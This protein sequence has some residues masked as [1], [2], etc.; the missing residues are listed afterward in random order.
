MKDNKSEKLFNSKVAMFE[1][2]SKSLGFHNIPFFANSPLEAVNVIRS[3]VVGGRDGYLR[4]DLDDLSLICVGFYD[5]AN[6]MI[7][8]TKCPFV[9]AE[10]SD[11]P[12]IKTTAKEGDKA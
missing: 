8:T 4:D 11:I 6:G 12:N 5:T 7:D 2:S 1:I 3:S 9:V 10:L